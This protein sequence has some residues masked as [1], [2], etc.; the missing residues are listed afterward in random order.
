[1]LIELSLDCV[2]LHC[3]ACVH[4]G[5]GPN[6]EP[7]ISDRDISGLNQSPRGIPH[8]VQLAVGSTQQNEAGHGGS[9]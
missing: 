4:P 2:G 3:Q 8:H 5:S 7:G 9:L 6:L 1:M